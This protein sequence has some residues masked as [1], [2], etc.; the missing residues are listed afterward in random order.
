MCG[1]ITLSVKSR[2]HDWALDAVGRDRLLRFAAWGDSLF[3]SP[4][5][6]FFVLVGYFVLWMLVV[7]GPPYLLAFMGRRALM[8]KGKVSQKTCESDAGKQ[9]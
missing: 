1:I 9:N 5:G 7:F 3:G 8:K 2:A 6:R 4:A